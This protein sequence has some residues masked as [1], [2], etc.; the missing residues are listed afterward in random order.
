VIALPGTPELAF[1]VSGAA[2]LV[3]AV[4]LLFLHIPPQ[5]SLCCAGK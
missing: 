5:N 4:T 1:V 3:S 2:I